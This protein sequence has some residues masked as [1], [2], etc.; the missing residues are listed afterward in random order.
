[1]MANAKSEHSF[2]VDDKMCEFG[3]TEKIKFMFRRKQQKIHSL[4]V[5]CHP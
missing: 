1:M 5:L 2:E 4:C 3:E